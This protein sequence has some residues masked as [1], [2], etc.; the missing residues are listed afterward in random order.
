MLVAAVKPTTLKT[1][2][3]SFYYS[4][5]L[6]CEKSTNSRYSDL[7][8]EMTSFDPYYKWL[9]I[10][11]EEQPANHYRLLGV[12]PFEEDIDVI[13]A[14][15]D[16][17]MA[18]VQQCAI[19][20]YVKQSQQVLN[21]LSS[22]RVCL[23]SSNKKSAYDWM[24]RR[25]EAGK[26]EVLQQE[27]ATSQRVQQQ[28]ESPPQ[29]NAETTP[30]AI[31]SS[32]KN[33]QVNPSKP[34]LNRKFIPGIVSIL[35]IICLLPVFG[36]LYYSRN[37]SSDILDLKP[38][39][40]D[41]PDQKV[42][43]EELLKFQ[44]AAHPMLGQESSNLRYRF[45]TNRPKSAK[46]NEVTGEFLWKP[47]EAD[48]PGKTPVSII[49]YLKSTPDQ[50]EEKNFLIHVSE[51]N[52]P[53]RI[54]NTPTQ[55]I[56]VNEETLLEISLVAND[57]DLPRN[58]L[59]YSLGD[60][61]PPG[62]SIDSKSGR[63]SWTPQEKDGPGFFSIPVVVTDDGQP[64]QK[65][66]YQLKLIVKE[67]NQPP[68]IAPVTNLSVRQGDAIKYFIKGTDSDI[69]QQ[70]LHYYLEEG[71]PKGSRID[72]NRG[73]FF[74]QVPSSQAIGQYFIQVRVTDDGT[75]QLSAM[76][77]FPL[78]VLSRPQEQITFYSGLKKQTDQIIFTQKMLTM[79]KVGW[80]KRK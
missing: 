1:A 17:K 19:G 13:E 79:L 49:A 14:A 76:V 8:D 62:S 23:L 71:A 48:G 24:L 34:F 77:K 57:S 59:T 45:G 75:N 27:Q 65:T 3:C 46:L 55:S 78:E 80:R 58:Q 38:L 18:Y 40:A 26:Q 16:Q 43:E 74:W 12:R 33:L 39:L 52:Q 11:A 7:V 28:L 68:E 6:F 51:V 29:P 25:D 61:A 32:G 44:L 50:T 21:E 47:T 5:T 41:V 2:W 70:T 9:G 37:N 20:E 67:V 72:E 69:P 35:F 30:Q 73:E 10:P 53:P 36:Y 60:N 42:N 63:F 22:A 15:A 64:S 56:I 4:N 66:E 54:K 31:P